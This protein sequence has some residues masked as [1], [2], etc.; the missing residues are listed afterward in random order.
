M[1]SSLDGPA[2]YG[3]SAQWERINRTQVT[4]D[5]VSTLA[6][7]KANEVN[8][9]LALWDPRVN[10]VRYLKTLIHH[11]GMNLSAQNLAR[12]RRTEHR[13]VGDPIA[14]RCQGERMCLDYLQAVFEL[15]FIA[16]QLPLDG[17]RV[18]EIGAGY[19]RT[20]HVLLSN[21]D[22][23]AYHIIDLDNSLNLARTYLGAVLTPQQLAKVTF[24]RID[25]VDRVTAA[26]RFDLCL[27][28]DSFAEMDAAT[29]H[30]YLDL[31]D[32]TCRYLYVCNPVG[33]YL[34]KSLDGHAQ[35]AETVALALRSG[36]LRD[37]IDIHDS[38]VVEAQSHKFLD[39]YRPGRDWHCLASDR[40]VPWSF[41]WQALY[42]RAAS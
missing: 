7:F 27:N 29:V 40:A 10:G 38:E 39:A 12:L 32:R 17:A 26:Q 3:R 31:V 25:D 41:Y 21:A 20:C 30:Q 19:G 4:A 6:G 35:G 16:R 8:F 24:T 9:K 42:A 22:I 23:E 11:L 13:D 18:L 28:V 33:K 1:Q 5:A 34:D 14:V 37:V 2:K 36:L 15:D